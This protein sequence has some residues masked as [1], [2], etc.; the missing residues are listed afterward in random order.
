MRQSAVDRRREDC[1][2]PERSGARQDWPVQINRTGERESFKGPENNIHLQ[3]YP[4]SLKRDKKLQNLIQTERWAVL[5]FK[6][7]FT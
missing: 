2:L 6:G 7:M 5:A 3:A 1:P 4:W